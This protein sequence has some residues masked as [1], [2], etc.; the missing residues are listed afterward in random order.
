MWHNVQKQEAFI[1]K[2]R[3]M[4]TVFWWKNLKNIDH[5]EDLGIDGRTMSPR[6][7]VKYDGRVLTAFI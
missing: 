6:I 3:K 5:L 4:H 1:E 7:L 2:T